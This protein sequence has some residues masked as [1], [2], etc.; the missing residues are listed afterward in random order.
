MGLLDST[1]IH[2]ETAAREALFATRNPLTQQLELLS[3]EWSAEAPNH[4]LTPTLF[5]PVAA[6]YTFRPG[7]CPA[8]PMSIEVD[9]KGFTRKVSGLPDA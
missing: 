2:L 7:L 8:E 3:K 4:P 1:Q 5:D 9:A 6:A